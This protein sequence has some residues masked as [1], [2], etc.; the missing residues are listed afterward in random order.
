MKTTKLS[1]ANIREKLSKEQMKQIL[2][3]TDKDCQYQGDPCC[4]LNPTPCGGIFNCCTGLACVDNTCGI[5][6]T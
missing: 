3:G 6:L 4:Q 1:L 2:A 5:P